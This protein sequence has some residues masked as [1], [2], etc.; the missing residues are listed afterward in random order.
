ML[1]HAPSHPCLS[2]RPIATQGFFSTNIGVENLRA[3]RLAVSQIARLGLV[4]PVVV[5]PNES[6]IELAHDFRVGLAAATGMRDVGFAAILEAGASRG[7]DRYVHAPKRGRGPAHMD[8]VGDVSGEWGVSLPDRLVMP[9]SPSFALKP[10]AP[11]PCR[12]PRR[13]HRGRHD[14]HRRVTG[15][16]IGAAA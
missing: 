2:C 11:P 8:L 9:P 14:R 6:C 3:T 1:L 16:A 5:A 15:E 7:T 12:R 13:G 4:R 10:L